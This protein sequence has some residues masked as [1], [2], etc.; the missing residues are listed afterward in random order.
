MS[1]QPVFFPFA[2]PFASCPESRHKSTLVLEIDTFCP[3]C[4]AASSAQLPFLLLPSSTT[5][6]QT[7]PAALS[8]YDPVSLLFS[9]ALHR[10]SPLPL[11]SLP[12]PIHRRIRVPDCALSPSLAS[13]SAASAVDNGGLSG[14]LWLPLMVVVEASRPDI[15]I[16]RESPSTPSPRLPTCRLELQCSHH[17]HPREPIDGS[18]TVAITTMPA[19]INALMTICQLPASLTLA[20]AGAADETTGSAPATRTSCTAWT[21][22]SPTLPPL[23]SL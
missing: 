7:T 9:S 3:L 16:P 13:T 23:P 6:T 21:P 18:P 15:P 4:F 14:L 22:L 19:R 1:C 17:P 10:R 12:I 11:P 8:S 2:W 20:I 5:R